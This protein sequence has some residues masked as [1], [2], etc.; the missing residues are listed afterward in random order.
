MDRNG[1]KWLEMAENLLKMAGYS[2]I[3]LEMARTGWKC[4][5]IAG[6]AGNG[7]KWLDWVEIAEKGQELK[8]W[9]EMA[10]NE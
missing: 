7:W 6:I 3:G 8:E 2:W 9:L 4:L 10:G 1:V 5:E